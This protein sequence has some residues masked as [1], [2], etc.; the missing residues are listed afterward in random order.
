MG[1]PGSNDTLDCR[2]GALFRLL[3]VVVPDELCEGT[4]AAS[5][6][7]CRDRA[8]FCVRSRVASPVSML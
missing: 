2:D 3:S 7:I 4:D 1:R 6:L 8:L 5:W